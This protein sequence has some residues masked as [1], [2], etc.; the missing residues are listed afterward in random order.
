MII[1]I[2]GSGAAFGGSVQI[3]VEGDTAAPLSKLYKSLP[4]SLKPL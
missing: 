1:W 2:Q 3:I 4:F